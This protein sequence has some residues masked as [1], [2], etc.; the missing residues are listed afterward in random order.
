MRTPLHSN[1]GSATALV[2]R[3]FTTFTMGETDILGGIVVANDE[4]LWHSL[5]LSPHGKLV[6]KH[7]LKF[8]K[9]MSP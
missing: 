5:K 2:D 1:L 8:F 9:I 3:R 6:T 7:G 4:S